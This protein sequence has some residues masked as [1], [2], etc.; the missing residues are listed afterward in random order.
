MNGLRWGCVA[1]DFTGASDLA[2]FLVNNNIKTLLI[3]GE[4]APDLKID[5]AIQAVIIALKT[6]TA[7]VGQAVDQS[8]RMFAWLQAKGCEKLY[9]KYCSTF[10]STDKGNI[11]PVIDAVLEKLGQPY[12]ILCPALPVNRR[13]V[14]DGR[15]YVNGVPL[16]NSSMRRHPLTPMLYSDIK[17]LIERQGKHKCLVVTRGDYAA[18]L[19]SVQEKLRAFAAENARFYVSVDFSERQHGHI[20]M[21]CFQELPFLTGGSGLAEGLAAAYWNAAGSSATAAASAYPQTKRFMLAGSCSDMTR[22]QIQTYINSGGRA[23]KIIP[24][25]LAAGKQTEAA[26]W[27]QIQSEPDRDILVYSAGASDNTADGKLFGGE[28][29]AA[30][31][32]QLMAGLAVRAAN[33][34][35]QNIIVA[36]GETS[37]A[38][39]DRLGLREFHVAESVDP[40][41]PVLI[42]V[43][44]SKLRIVLKSGNFG[45]EDFFLKALNSREAQS[46]LMS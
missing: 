36:G 2:S 32:E 4:P 28:R 45:G 11:G 33:A 5:D 40:G 31:L 30:M 7:P 1:D 38:V 19:A 12:T 25:A 21:Q 46:W 18:G 35:C 34:G 20:I 27:E 6:R 23:V 24:Q 15:L 17:V 37:G 8:L 10:D 43:Q 22:R 26:V 3:C 44:D 42:P 41:V 16:E 39:V 14:I 9:F 13:E 29:E